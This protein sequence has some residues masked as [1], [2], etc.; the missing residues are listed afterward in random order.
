[1]ANCVPF[2]AKWIASKVSWFSAIWI[3]CQLTAL[4]KSTLSILSII[5]QTKDWDLYKK[6]K[7]SDWH[8]QTVFLH[9]TK[10]TCSTKTKIEWVNQPKPPFVSMSLIEWR[11]KAGN[12]MGRKFSGHQVTAMRENNQY[13]SNIYNWSNWKNRSCDFFFI[14]S[15][16][17]SIKSHLF[18]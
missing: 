14:T 15:P 4:E 2:Y 3:R 5:T 7:L 1:L 11:K 13:L 17:F 10:K 6:C 9:W 18:K 16:N 8:K 12:G